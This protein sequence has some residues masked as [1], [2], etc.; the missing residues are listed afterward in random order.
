[1]C[2]Y[3]FAFGENLNMI[4]IGA[5]FID[6]RTQITDVQLVFGTNLKKLKYENLKMVKFYNYLFQNFDWL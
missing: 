1:M 2:L 6:F 3:F 5:Y 4:N